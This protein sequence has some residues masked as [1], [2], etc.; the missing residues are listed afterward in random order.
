[1]TWP[2]YSVACRSAV[3]DLL[4]RG[5]S[6]SAYRAN[7]DYGVEPR[8]DSWACR[9]ERQLERRMGVKHAV[10]VN[11]GTAALH[12]G[13]VNLDLRGGEVITSPYTFSATA[14]AI[15]LAGGVPVFADVDSDSFCITKETVKRVVTRRTKAILPVHLFGG[16]AKTD[17]IA[18]LGLPIVEDACQ[19][20]GSHIGGRHSGSFSL[21]GAYSFNG[22]KNIPAGE[23]GAFVT[24]SDSLAR[25]ARLLMNHAENFGTDYVSY[26]YRPN[27]LTAC[28][29]YHGLMELNENN[30]ER[31]SLA[32]ALTSYI[33]AEKRLE[34]FIEIPESVKFDGSH[35]YYVYCFKLKNISRRLFARRMKDRWN[36]HVG[37]GYINP[38]LHEYKAFK[39]YARGPLPVAEELSRKSLC[40]FSHVTPGNTI[41][42]M[43]RTVKAMVNCV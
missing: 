38:C 41:A 28:V 9:L 40:L 1:M 21:G 13:L 15:V 22:G 8:L 7:K 34:R 32:E 16:M 23:C 4:R 19:A 39:K 30:R 24:N 36:I 35:V 29:A 14:S 26:N 43:E 10:V 17:E 33:K 11:S 12:A 25:S 2:T 18:S 37:E 42:E 20:V 5:G 31:I 6:L 3:D 27:E